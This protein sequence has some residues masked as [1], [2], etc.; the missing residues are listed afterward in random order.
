MTGSVTSSTSA[1]AAAAASSGGSA[2]TQTG[3]AALNSLSGNFSDF[4]SLLMTQLQNQDPTSPLDSNQFTSEL[5]QFSSVEQQINTNS[6]LTQLIQLTQASQ[7]E[8]SSSMLGKQVT[9]NS[10]QLALQNGSAAVNFTTTS[11]EPVAIAVSNAAGVQV[12]S[13]TLTSTA[14]SNTWN[15]NGQNGNGT[16]LPDG[17]YTVSVM[18]LGT[19]G[20]TT[21]V[22]FT[23]TGTATSVVNNSGTVD[24]EMGA[25]SLPFSDVV[26]VGK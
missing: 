6:D 24:L 8:Q 19:S 17:A 4:L 3:S 23:V 1:A 9:V 11:P 7:V 21:A 22:P 15:W 13:A 12:A 10:T 18:A 25:L 16:Q 5:V 2:A 20:S 26:S 14:G